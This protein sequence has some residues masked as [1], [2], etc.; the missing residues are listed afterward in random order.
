LF[1]WGLNDCYP[2]IAAA[3]IHEH[4]LAQ[5]PWQNNP[6]SGRQGLQTG[7]SRIRHGQQNTQFRRKQAYGDHYYLPKG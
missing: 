6:Q 2:S 7:S 1:L 5:F 4:I 3:A